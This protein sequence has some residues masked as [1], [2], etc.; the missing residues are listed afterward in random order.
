MLSIYSSEFA[1][2][3]QPDGILQLSHRVYYSAELSGYLEE[4][5]GSLTF[6]G[7]DYTYLRG[8]FIN[9]GCAVVPVTLYD[10]CGLTL[11]ANLFMNDAKWRPD[12]CTVECQVVDDSFLSLIDNNKDIKAYL[13]VARSK[14]DVAITAVTQTNL[15][16]TAYDSVNNS[17]TPADRCGVRVYDALRML[18][19][20]MSDGLIGFESDFFFPDDDPAVSRPRIPTLITGR[21]IRENVTDSYPFIS[22]EELFKDLNRLYNLAFSVERTIAGVV[23]RI[24][25]KSYFRD[26]SPTLTM[27]NVASVE[28]TSDASSLYSKVT[29]GTYKQDEFV[30]YPGGASPPSLPF[31]AWSQEE[32]HLGGQCNNQSVL[33]LQL[34]T[35]IT[36]TN[37]IMRCL[38]YGAPNPQTIVNP[39]DT[40]YDEDTFIVVFDANNFTIQSDNPIYPTLR[41]Y[42]G[43]LTNVEVAQRW[44]DGIP[45]PIFLFLDGVTNNDAKGG[46]SVN[47]AIDTDPLPPFFLGQWFFDNIQFSTYNAIMEFPVRTFPIGYDPSTNMADGVVTTGFNSTWYEAPNAGVYTIVSRVISDGDMQQMIIAQVRAGVLV[48]TSEIFYAQPEQVLYINRTFELTMTVAAAA[49]DRF[50]VVCAGAGSLAYSPPNIPAIPPILKT[51]SYMEVFAQANQI[52]HTYDPAD[53][54]LIN[55]SFNYPMASNDWQSFVSSKFGVIEITHTNGAVRGFLKEANRKLNDGMTEFVIR[56]NFANS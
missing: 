12:L 34:E 4:F 10:S 26:N 31:V 25:P 9:D 7:T 24:E 37:V 11:T 41:Y 28:Q 45:Y 8:R 47:A 32:Y 36:D 50:Y 33:E 30:F 46:L 35:L 44:G 17:N 22:F 14:N 20:F 49:G 13:N 53:N 38:P 51:G 18:V 39:P 5:E 52:T 29:Y 23:L 54:Y 16:F 55:S 42:N 1:I 56:S 21:A 6:F 48:Q 19:E 27:L 3:N 15:T 43:R 2:A 40:S